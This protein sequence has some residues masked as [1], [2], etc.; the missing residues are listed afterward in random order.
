MHFSS[1]TDSIWPTSNQCMSDL[2]FFLTGF[3]LIKMPEYQKQCTSV[4]VVVTLENTIEGLTSVEC[5]LHQN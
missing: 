1:V 3:L 4:R 5:A 2:I